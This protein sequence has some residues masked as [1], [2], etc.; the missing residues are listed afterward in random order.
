MKT[1]TSAFTQRRISLD[2]NS[3][4]AINRKKLNIIHPNIQVSTRKNWILSAIANEKYLN[5]I[6]DGETGD[7][8]S[9]VNAM[10]DGEF[11]QTS[12]FPEASRKWSPNDSL[13]IPR[14]NESPS[15]DILIGGDRIP[16]SGNAAGACKVWNG[17]FVEDDSECVSAR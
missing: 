12:V 17:E 6:L 10:G 16:E 7:S 3:K 11:G 9:T 15:E 14:S 2:E 4:I 5:R 13:Q 1:R 8:I